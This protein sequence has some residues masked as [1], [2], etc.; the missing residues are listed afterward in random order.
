M[1]YFVILIILVAFSAG[2]ESSSEKTTEKP[3]LLVQE[4]EETVKDWTST[5]PVS[6]LG[7]EVPSYWIPM[8]ILGCLMGINVFMVTLGLGIASTFGGIDLIG[9]LD[10][11]GK[12]WIIL[13]SAAAF[14]ADQFL[15]KI[16]AFE[17]VYNWIIIAIRVPIAIWMGTAMLGGFEGIVAG[18]IAGLINDQVAAGITNFLTSLGKA[19][20]RTATLAAGGIGA[21]VNPF[22]SV[23]EDIGIWFALWA[24]YDAGMLT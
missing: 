21:G 6:I 9:D 8:L 18:S 16:P 19:G 14:V 15:D 7:F 24:M 13:I 22:I 4:V 20:V 10:A 2:C 12:I 11:L 5:D 3:F 1:R 17:T 23:G